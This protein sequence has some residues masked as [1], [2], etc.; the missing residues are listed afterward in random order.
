MGRSY[1]PKYALKVLTPT[2]FTTPMAWN[3]HY[4]SAFSNVAAK[5][6]M[7]AYNKSIRPGG[8]NQHLGAGAAALAITVYRQSDKVVTARWPPAFH[9]PGRTHHTAKWRR[10]VRA[11]KR[12]G[13]AYSPYAV[14]TARY[15]PSRLK[16]PVKTRRAIKAAVKIGRH[17]V[18]HFKAHGVPSWAI[19]KLSPQVRGYVEQILKYNGVRVVTPNP[20]RRH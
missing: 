16:N 12:R 17:L 18:T 6:F 14:A 11:I 19:G 9:N 1:T 13:G 15:G 8:V 7:D 2:G 5:K 4:G 20:R 10:M 3:R